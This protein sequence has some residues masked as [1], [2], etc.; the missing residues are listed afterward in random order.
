[1]Q[2]CQ[3][4]AWLRLLHAWHAAW[5]CVTLAG[6]I[7]LQQGSCQCLPLI[8]SLTNYVQDGSQNWPSRQASRGVVS[9]DFS[10]PLA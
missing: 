4:A 7:L 8:W 6:R 5:P 1:M 3:A 9:A 2:A 10:L